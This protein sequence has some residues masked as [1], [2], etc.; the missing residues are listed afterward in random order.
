MEITKFWVKVSRRRVPGA[1]WSPGGFH[2]KAGAQ[3]QQV[4]K[5]M[6]G[7]RL[8]GDT[9]GLQDCGTGAQKG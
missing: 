3:G 8:A 1:T 9:E 6:K 4:H 7:S 2:A 5:V